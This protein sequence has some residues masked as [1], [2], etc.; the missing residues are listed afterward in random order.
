MAKWFYLIDGQS[1]GPIESAALKQLADSGHLKPEDKVRREDL[2]TWHGA[3]SVKG[4]FP[5]VPVLTD[6][7]TSDGMP[8]AEPAKSAEVAKSVGSGRVPVYPRQQIKVS[9]ADKDAVDSFREIMDQVY[10]AAIEPNP[11]RDP[12]YK[13]KIVVDDVKTGDEMT[14]WLTSFIVG[15]PE[16]SLNFTLED[17]GRVIAGKQ[18]AS[19]VYFRYT[20]DRDFMAS[21]FGG[22][23]ASFI[24]SNCR[25]LARQIT[26][27]VAEKL[28]MPESDRKVLRKALKGTSEIIA[29]A[30]IGISAAVLGIGLAVTGYTVSAPRD[31]MPGLFGGLVVGVMVGIVVGAV[32][33][34]FHRLYL[35]IRGR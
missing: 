12:K 28:A 19:A 9:G 5:P 4:L 22:T 10:N 24:R 2:T 16:V 21:S 7:V 26:E 31:K 35:K 6:E 13:L 32:L 15:R 25:K 17:D 20:C 34:M 8:I 18:L 14:R 30:Y 23:N 1:A 3:E 33:S 29:L 27:E 11:F